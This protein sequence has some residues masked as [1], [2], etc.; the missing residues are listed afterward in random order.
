[1][2]LVPFTAPSKSLTSEVMSVQSDELN[3]PGEM[4]ELAC[5]KLPPSRTIS[6]EL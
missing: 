3:E 1:M 5:Q 6:P 2:A 4:F